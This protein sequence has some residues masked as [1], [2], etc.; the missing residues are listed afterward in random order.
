MESTPRD[1]VLDELLN[2]RERLLML[3]RDCEKTG[4]LEGAAA[5]AYD[6]ER[7]EGVIAL[8]LLTSENAARF[9]SR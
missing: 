7:C 6:L 9:V 4:E 5:L 8:A 2:R 1:A 3:L